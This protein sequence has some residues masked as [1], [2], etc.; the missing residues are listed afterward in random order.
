MKS[1]RQG[2][3]RP[4]QQWAA[5]AGRQKLFDEGFDVVV[6]DAPLEATTLHLR[7]VDT[8]LPRKPSDRRAG[9]GSR[10]PRLV[11]RR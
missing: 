2:R 4:S 6:S 9:V 3:I 10:K 11:D 1:R 8:Q 7:Q 5:P